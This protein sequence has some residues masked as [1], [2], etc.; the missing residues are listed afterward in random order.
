M[1]GWPSRVTATDIILVGQLILYQ[2]RSSERDFFELF[3][4][5][6]RCARAALS[7]RWD[8]ICFII[9]SQI[10]TASVDTDKRIM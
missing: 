5:G 10:A 9:I 4:S 2:T 7:S 1:I 8:E 3:G 6:H